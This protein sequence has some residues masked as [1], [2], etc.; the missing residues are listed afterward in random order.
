MNYNEIKNKFVGISRNIW[1]ASL[2]T[3]ATIGQESRNL[4]KNIVD[5]KEEVDIKEQVQFIFKPVEKARSWSLGFVRSMSTTL[6]KSSFPSS[7]HL[8][9]LTSRVERMINR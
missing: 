5:K 4:F 9:K 2:G 1:L 8:H 7:N 3:V 6:E